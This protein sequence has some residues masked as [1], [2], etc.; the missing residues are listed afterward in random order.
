MEVGIILIGYGGGYYFDWLWTG[1]YFD[2]L[3]RW[4]LSGLTTE[5]GITGLPL[6][7]GFKVEQD[8][9]EVSGLA[10]V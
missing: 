2:W 3:R 9:K 8:R 5:V 1:H 7:A 10:V 4:A 6:G